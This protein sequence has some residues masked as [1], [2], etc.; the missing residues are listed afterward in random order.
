M[1]PDSPFSAVSNDEEIEPKQD[2][3][4]AADVDESTGANVASE[5]KDETIKMTTATT[6]SGS[7]SPNENT[8]R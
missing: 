3:T 8:S 2:E 5:L 7:M 4:T 6:T 1:S